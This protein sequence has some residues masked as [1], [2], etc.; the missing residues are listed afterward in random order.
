MFKP[1]R[2]QINKQII[3]AAAE[4]FVRENIDSLPEYL[5]SEDLVEHLV[6]HFARHKDGFELAKDLECEGWDITAETVQLL[7][8]FDIQIEDALQVQKK[9]GLKPTISSRR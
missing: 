7:D 5:E 4:V 3:E 8:E 6:K 9:N 2:P 1:K